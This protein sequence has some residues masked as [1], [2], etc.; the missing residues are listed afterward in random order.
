MGMSSTGYV[1]AW[2]SKRRLTWC[3][4]C[5]DV[6]FGLELKNVSFCTWLLCIVYM[7][8][9]PFMGR[10]QSTSYPKDAVTVFFPAV[11]VPHKIPARKPADSVCMLLL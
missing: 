9:R 3:V 2:L 6:G 11:L 1:D 4:L 5:V 10:L 8:K 7:E